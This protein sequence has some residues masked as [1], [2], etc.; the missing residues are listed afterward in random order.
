[1]VELVFTDDE[2][3]VLARIAG[4]PAFPAAHRCDLDDAAWAAI[5]RG[6]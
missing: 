6:G 3:T 2:L 4:E 1:M 5:A